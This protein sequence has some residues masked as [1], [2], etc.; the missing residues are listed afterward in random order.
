MFA[1]IDCDVFSHPKPMTMALSVLV[2]IEMLN[3]LNSLSENQ[4]LLLMPP[5]TNKWLLGAICLS[6]CLHF[7]ILYV[8]VMSVIFQITP[9]NLEEWV[10]VMKISIP[11]I[12]LDE[13][14]KFVARKFADDYPGFF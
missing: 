13:T 14:L 12:L 10:A 5:W 9:L 2:L 8:D 6:M 1:G 3:A 7:F 4:S 11:V